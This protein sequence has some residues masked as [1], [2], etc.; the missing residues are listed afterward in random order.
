LTIDRPQS[1]PADRRW[2]CFSNRTSR[3]DTLIWDGEDQSIYAGGRTGPQLK[4]DMIRCHES[5]F[6]GSLAA[7]IRRKI[8]VSVVFSLHGNPDIDLKRGRMPEPFERLSR[9]IYSYADRRCGSSKRFQSLGLARSSPFPAIRRLA[10]ARHD[11]VLVHTGQ[12][13]GYGMSDVCFGEMSAP[14]PNVNVSVGSGS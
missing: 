3:Q 8:G 6:D 11:A 13:Y 2:E 12:H 1:F 14:N 5:G 4:P 9:S 10:E 7:R